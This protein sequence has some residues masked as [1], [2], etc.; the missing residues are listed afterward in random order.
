MKPLKEEPSENPDQYRSVTIVCS[1]DACEAAKSITGKH[2]FLRFVHLFP[3]PLPECDG[4]KCLCKYR[5]HN[6]RR[7]PEDRRS[8]YSYTVYLE[9]RAGPDRRKDKRED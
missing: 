3:L 2:I 4:R 8:P 1:N 6:D 7:D 5:H 9:R